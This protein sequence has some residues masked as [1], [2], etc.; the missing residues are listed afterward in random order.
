MYIVDQGS[1]TTGQVFKIVPVDPTIS[2]ADLNCD[3]AVGAFDL[4][5]LLISWGPC[6]GCLADLDGDHIVGASDLLILLFN[7]G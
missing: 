6:D 4:L 1:G 7:W 2:L 3:G 5:R